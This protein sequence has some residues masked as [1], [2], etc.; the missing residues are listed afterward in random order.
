MVMSGRG[1]LPR[2]HT[3]SLLTRQL[4]HSGLARLA[5]QT[6]PDLSGAAS[7]VRGLA[8]LVQP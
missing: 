7:L 2:N 8:P 5:S 6:G 4:E 1:W 3:C